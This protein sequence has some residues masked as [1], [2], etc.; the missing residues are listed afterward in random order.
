MMMMRWAIR[1]GG[2]MPRL[3]KEGWMAHR[4]LDLTPVSQC[5]L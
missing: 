5:K 4:C 3:K 1:V 2:L